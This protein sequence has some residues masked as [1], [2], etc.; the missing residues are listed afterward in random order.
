MAFNIRNAAVRALRK[1]LGREQVPAKRR[2]AGSDLA[3]MGTKLSKL[4]VHDARSAD[5]ILGY[6]ENELPN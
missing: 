4:R 5:E 2:K 6:D 3:K 1:R